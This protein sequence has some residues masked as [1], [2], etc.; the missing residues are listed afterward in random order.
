[1]K[2]HNNGHWWHV[3]T[4]LPKNP[5]VNLLNQY[6]LKFQNYPEYRLLLRPPELLITFE[7][8]TIGPL[9]IWTCPILQ[10]KP[11]PVCLQTEALYLCSLLLLFLLLSYLLFIYYHDFIKH[12]AFIFINN[13]SARS[14]GKNFTGRRLFCALE[15]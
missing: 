3:G 12:I 2:Y 1:M 5:A 11:S 6:F 4:Y 8:S 7:D 10:A 9:F 14:F 15:R 13:F